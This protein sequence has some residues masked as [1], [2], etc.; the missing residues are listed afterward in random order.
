MDEN[1][2]MDCT[3]DRVQAVNVWGLMER[4]VRWSAFFLRL[5]CISILPPSQA[6]PL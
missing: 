6:C 3:L 2:K 1:T 5:C 4:S